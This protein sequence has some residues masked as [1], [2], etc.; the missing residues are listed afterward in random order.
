M[1]RHLL[2][3]FLTVAL[4]CAS[5]A[6]AR[7][8]EFCYDPYPPYALGTDGP[9][10]GGLKVSLLEEVV[11]RV[12]GITAS[13]TIMPWRRC[14]A[15][16]AS[17]HLDGILPLFPN[18]ERGEYMVFT[19]DTFEEVSVFWY[20]RARF[21]DG[22]DWSGDYAD[23]DG[24]TLGMLIGGYI[25]AEMEAY[26]S[27][28]GDIL[29]AV[30]LDALLLMVLHGR[31][32]LI[33]IDGTVGRHFV[34]VTGNAERMAFVERPIASQASQFGL[35]RVTGAD[36]YLEDFNAAIAE[37]HAEGRIDALLNSLP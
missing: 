36:V 21:P 4:L 23:L 19:D 17:G 12:D 15:E 25:D 22:L 7:N 35:S 10:E 27:A 28:S 9:A 34:H 31:V 18:A 37:L 6:N 1:R 13:V 5:A 3:G 16:V 26:F 24:L 32:D 33:A 11:A 2:R 8:L 20:D 30:D 29:R 14:Q